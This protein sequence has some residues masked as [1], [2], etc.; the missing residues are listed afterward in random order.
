MPEEM[1]LFMQEE[2]QEGAAGSRL[3]Y[4]RLYCVCMVLGSDRREWE[5]CVAGGV[6]VSREGGSS[7]GNEGRR[8][9]VTRRASPA[10]G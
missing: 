9:F 4:G 10:T 5:G 1:T 2:E 3:V 6:E 7:V 8:E